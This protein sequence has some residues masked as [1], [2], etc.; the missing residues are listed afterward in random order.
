MFL[1]EEQSVPYPYFGQLIG[2]SLL[3]KLEKKGKKSPC[4]FLLRMQV[5]IHPRKVLAS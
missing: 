3:K 1:A 5:Y 2:E 4:R